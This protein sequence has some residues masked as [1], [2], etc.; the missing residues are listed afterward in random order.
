[1]WKYKIFT[2]ISPNQITR[3]ILWQKLAKLALCVSL[4]YFLLLLYGPCL[5]QIK[6]N[7]NVNV[8][9]YISII[10]GEWTSAKCDLFCEV[11]SIQISS[12]SFT[13]YDTC[14]HVGSYKR[15][16]VETFKTSGIMGEVS[17]IASI[18]WK[19]KRSSYHWCYRNARIYLSN[20]WASCLSPDGTNCHAV[21]GIRQ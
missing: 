12:T 20:I 17:C 16:T 13:S 10:S 5:I 4:V 8:N 15:L 21:V 14:M 6:C 9:L 3:P 18:N 11:R 7:V 1:M 2:R 19:R